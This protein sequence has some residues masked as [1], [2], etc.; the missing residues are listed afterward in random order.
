MKPT[1]FNHETPFHSIWLL[2]QTHT[3]LLLPTCTIGRDEEDTHTLTHEILDPELRNS[4]AQVHQL[5]RYSSS[6]EGSGGDEL[7]SCEEHTSLRQLHLLL[8]A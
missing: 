1:R 7:S 8:H 6:R 5:L 3:L 4:A 2:I